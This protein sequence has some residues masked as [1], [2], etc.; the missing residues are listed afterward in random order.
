MSDK[1]I[2][3]EIVLFQS[4]DGAAAVSVTVEDVVRVATLDSLLDSVKPDSV[5]AP[6]LAMVRMQLASI[7]KAEKP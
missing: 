3:A 1:K 2:L 7:L 6:M 4:S 5:A